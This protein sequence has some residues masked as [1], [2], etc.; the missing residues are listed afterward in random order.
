MI[1]RHKSTATK[2]SKMLKKMSK[3]LMFDF[4]TLPKTAKTPIFSAISFA[5]LFFILY[6]DTN[7]RTTPQHSTLP[8]PAD[9]NDD[10][11][12]H[13]FELTTR[14]SIDTNR[15]EQK[16]EEAVVDPLVP[17]VNVTIAGRIEW[18]RQKLPEL[19]LLNSNDELSRSF[20]GR[21]VDFFNNNCSVQFYMVWLSPARTFGPR[22][23]LAADTLFKSNPNACL[24][25]VSRSMDSKTGTRKLQPLLDLGFKVLAVTPNVPFLVED[26]PGEDWLAEMKTGTKDPG[27]IPLTI[28]LSNLIRIAMIYK[29]GGVYLDTDFIVLKDFS[30]LR[31]AVGAQTVDSTTNQ[32]SSIN[33]AVIIFD[34]GHPMVLEFIKEFANTFNGNKWGNNGPAMFTRVFERVVDVQRNVTVMPPNAFYPVD[35]IEIRKLFKMP[36][37]M[38]RSRW[39]DQV[40]SDME[41]DSYALHLWNKRSRQLIVEEGSVMDRLISDHCVVC[42]HINHA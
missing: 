17:P 40:L 11:N 9:A 19:D 4:R 1:S 8:Y 26:T 10:G 39:A 34:R 23:F 15:E 30:G 20:H 28:N 12:A 5:T 33:N 27:Y 18:F 41:R 25:I 24:V 21:V 2:F 13:R 14:M 6:L 22:E 29:Y 36:M 16:E 7:F 3:K 35:W 42:Q 38:S 32:W 37:T 31:N